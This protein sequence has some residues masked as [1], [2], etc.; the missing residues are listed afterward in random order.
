MSE[1]RLQID[2]EMV[3][4]RGKIQFTGIVSHT[5]QAPVA[6]FYAWIDDRYREVEMR[7]GD[8]AMVGDMAFELCDL[9]R[10]KSH[11]GIEVRPITEV[12]NAVSLGQP[13]EIHLVNRFALVRAKP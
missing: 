9:G 2:Q 8:I 3:V 12:Q 5:G 11:V 10:P 7:V 4:T 13:F 6:R 1:I